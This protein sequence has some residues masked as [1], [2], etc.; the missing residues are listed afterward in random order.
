MNQPALKRAEKLSESCHKVMRLSL[1]ENIAK[2]KTR[3]QIDLNLD[4]KSKPKED[5]EQETK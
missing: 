2:K 3:T 1:F 5:E 4:K